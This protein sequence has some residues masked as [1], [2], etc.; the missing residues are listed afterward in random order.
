MAGVVQDLPAG[1]FSTPSDIDDEVASSFRGMSCKSL[2]RVD[3]RGTDIC[4]LEW[5]ISA[6]V[7]KLQ[8]IRSAGQDSGDAG[9]SISQLRDDTTVSKRF[10]SR[11]A[12]EGSKSSFRAEAGFSPLPVLQSTARLGSQSMIRKSGN[13][14][15]E[16]VMLKQRE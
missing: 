3:E 15:S 8:L 14:F 6:D 9:S 4:L 11:L 5:L 16:K 13:R 10:P 1:G 7:L 12:S 2:F